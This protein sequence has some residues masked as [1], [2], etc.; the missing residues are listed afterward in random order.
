MRGVAERA[1]H[2]H[3]H[4]KGLVLPPELAKLP[5]KAERHGAF[6]EGLPSAKQK[7]A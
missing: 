6:G 4:A 1:A 3:L 5:H 2:P 7:S